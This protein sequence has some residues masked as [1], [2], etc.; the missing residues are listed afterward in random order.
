MQ[1][2]IQQNVY[3]HHKKF[4]VWNLTW[5][6]FLKKL[7][8]IKL[9]ILLNSFHNVHLMQPQHLL[10]IFLLHMYRMHCRFTNA[11]KSSNYKWMFH[12]AE[13][14]RWMWERE[15]C[16][17]ESNYSTLKGAV[18]SSSC[19]KDSLSELWDLFFIQKHLS[20]TFFTILNIF[21]LRCI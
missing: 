12:I 15:K 4:Y 14:S 10:E 2:K 1:P 11:E 5:I 16:E 7:C 17:I 21:P 19:K 18:Y 13:S 3:L 8:R 6:Y 20:G 9:E